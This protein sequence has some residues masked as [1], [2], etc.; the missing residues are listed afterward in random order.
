MA[1]SADGAVLLVGGTGVVGRQIAEAVRHRH[2]ELKLVLAG[3]DGARAAA[4]ARELGAAAGIAVDVG[5]PAPLAGLAPAVVVSAV[6]D[7]QD[8][9]LRDAV[10]RGVPLLDIARWTDRVRSAAALVQHASPGAPVLLSSGWMAGTCATL[11]AGAASGMAAV[12]SIDISVLY[13]LK[14]KAGPDSAEY[15]DRLATP[16]YVTVDCEECEVRPLG[17]GRRV[18]FPGARTAR[19]YRF[20]TPD[21][22]TLPRTTGARTVAARIGFDD[23]FTTAL[24]VSLVRSGAW[25]LI[26]GERFTGLRRKLLYN[27]G[28]GAGHHVVI[29]VHGAGADGRP[30]SRRLAVAD[31]RGQTHLTAV[32][33]LVQLERLLGLDGA[34]APAPGLAYPDSAPQL[35]SALRV[36]REHGVSVDGV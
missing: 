6:N 32:A 5:A 35:A 29:D 4:V 11:A 23:A 25:R 24:L 27:P 9:L 13:A 1:A 21:Q 16:F 15:M 8:H 22:L 14:D 30:L 28:P 31:A 7:P 17:D 19:V 10:E 20:D 2:P 33:A 12:D 18:D 36:L 3:R 34:P 26:S